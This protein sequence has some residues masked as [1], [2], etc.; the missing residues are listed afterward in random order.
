M[1][2]HRLDIK[3]ACSTS[4]TQFCINMIGNKCDYENNINQH[5]KNH[6]R[7]DRGTVSLEHGF[8]V[9][10]QIAFSQDH[11]QCKYAWKVWRDRC[12]HKCEHSS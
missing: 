2:I 7:V 11:I 6:K 8:V 9:Y 12:G 5:N 3:C 1:I 10:T 4:T